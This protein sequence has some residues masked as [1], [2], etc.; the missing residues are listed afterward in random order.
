LPTFTEFHRVLHLEP[1][2]ITLR[3]LSV[4]SS[5]RL[6]SQDITELLINEALIDQIELAKA[7]PFQL[8]QLSFDSGDFSLFNH[9]SVKARI[10][11]CIEILRELANISLHLNWSYSTPSTEHLS[12]KMALSFGFAQLKR[13]KNLEEKEQALRYTL[14]LLHKRYPTRQDLLQWEASN[15]Y[16]NIVRYSPV[17]LAWRSRLMAFI[18]GDLGTDNQFTILVRQIDWG[19]LQRLNIATV[20]EGQKIVNLLQTDPNSLLTK[21]RVI[22]EQSISYIY[23]QKYPHSPAAT[24]HNMLQR[25]DRDAVFPPIISIYLT[26]LRTSGNVGAHSTVGSKEDVEVLLPLFVRVLEWFLDRVC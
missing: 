3:E 2:G 24:L 13:L 12:K 7:F 19:A 1:E 20:D 6:L 11:T 9:F 18:Q 4:L 23:Q 16:S 21:L 8:G 26:T 14:D 5:R 17:Y 15:L 22:I 10:G 25:L